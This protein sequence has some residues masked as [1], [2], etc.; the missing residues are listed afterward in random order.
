[1]G[2]CL[3][4]GHTYGPDAW[5]A[6][7]CGRSLPSHADTAPDPA[8][9][10]GCGMAW[11]ICGRCD[12]ID[13]HHITEHHITEHDVTEHDVTEHDVTEHAVT[14]QFEVQPGGHLRQDVPAGLGLPN[15]HNATEENP[16]VEPS[17]TPVGGVA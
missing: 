8:G 3:M 16:M 13:E 1:M 7:D 12:H 11:R 17:T 5:R 14:E 15:H 2:I 10:H 4:C 9:G 6:C